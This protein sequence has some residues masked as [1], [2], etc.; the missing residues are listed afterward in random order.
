M[1]FVFLPISAIALY[2]VEFVRAVFRT[3]FMERYKFSCLLVV[4]TLVLSFI[5]ATS[6]PTHEQLTLDKLLYLGFYML[7]TS[8]LWIEYLR[9]HKMQEIDYNRAWF[10]CIVALC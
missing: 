9:H 4:L 10:P 3:G 7:M 5:E 6:G 8:V 2:A 1:Q